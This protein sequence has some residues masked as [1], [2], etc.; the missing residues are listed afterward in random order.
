[1]VT[2]VT[3]R[4]RIYKVIDSSPLL[5]PQRLNFKT[6][7]SSQCPGQ[8]CNQSVILGTQSRCLEIIKKI[9]CSGLVILMQPCQSV[10]H[11]KTHPGEKSMLPN[12]KIHNF[13]YPIYREPLT[14]LLTI[15]PWK[16]FRNYH[17]K[18]KIQV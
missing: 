13:Q 7:N 11:I 17:A 1:M 3:T 10:N 12:G 5:Y 9:K 14:C 15:L 4:S 16:S 2:K 18:L 8:Q 6:N